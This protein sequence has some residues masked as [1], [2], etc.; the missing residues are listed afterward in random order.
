MDALDILG[1]MHVEAK[2]AFEEIESA[3]A[4]ERGDLWDKL[5]PQLALHEDLEERFVYDPVSRDAGGRD[6]VLA[7]WEEEHEAQV[8]EAESVMTAIDALEPTDDAWL[9]QVAALHQT[10][11]GHIA[12]EEDD[13]WPRIREVWGEGRLEEVGEAMDQAKKAAKA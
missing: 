8:A 4:E 5:E 3:S 13:I 12:H 7:A 10:L 1:Q 11:E 9:S 2:A 6:A